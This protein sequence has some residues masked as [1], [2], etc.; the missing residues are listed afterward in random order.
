MGGEDACQKQGCWNAVVEEVITC[1]KTE[2]E[3]YHG[4]DETKDEALVAVLFQIL[5]VHLQTC[6]EHDVVDAHLAEQFERC[7]SCKEIEAVFA[8]QH[9]CQ[10]HSDEMR[11]A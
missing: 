1:Q 8:N 2:T 11:N 9:T 10:N 3:R 7:V 4:G 6:Q 5:Q